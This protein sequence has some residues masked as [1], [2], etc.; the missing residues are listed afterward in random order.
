MQADSGLECFV[1][2]L[3]SYGL[4][5][6]SFPWWMNA[7]QLAPCPPCFS[8]HASSCSS[9]MV[10]WGAGGGDL[11][12]YHVHQHVQ[13]SLWTQGGMGAA[14]PHAVYCLGYK[15]ALF[16]SSGHSE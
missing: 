1:L 11:P 13:L 14:L 6:P 3:S 16:F 5:Q 4:L 10:R 15:A 12:K 8:H 7:A 2:G 9:S